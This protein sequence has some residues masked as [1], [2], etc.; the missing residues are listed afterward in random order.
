MDAVNSN[1][2]DKKHIEKSPNLDDVNN[3]TETKLKQNKCSPASP[4]YSPSTPPC[5]NSP[6]PPPPPTSIHHFLAQQIPS[7]SL[8]SS[9][10]D[11][12][13]F[14]RSRDLM[15]RLCS[16]NPQFTASVLEDYIR[17]IFREGDV[18][19]EIECGNNAALM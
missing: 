19:L 10:T 6:P 12:A 11:R 15:A 5:R 4:T 3:N 8:A 13:A 14:S 16:S 1:D 17:P 18:V 9:P 2:D 7:P